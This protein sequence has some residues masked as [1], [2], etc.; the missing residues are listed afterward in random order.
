M[1][2]SRAV[3]LCISLL[4]WI[5]W[6]GACASREPM[7]TV[8][9]VDLQRFMGDWYVIA[10]I[11]AFIEKKAYDEV[12][13]YELK[14]NGRIAT[15]LTFRKGAFDGPTKTYRPSARVVEGTGNAEWRMQFLWPFESEY[16][17]IYLDDDYQ[18]TIVGRT[19]RDYAW[20]MSRSPSIP[21]AQY[22][23]LVS[24]LAD[25][26]YDTDKLREVPQS[27]R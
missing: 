18:T 2:E 20:I 9:A 15:T 10:H 4:S 24:F 8:Q 25:L 5:P 22:D 16:L 6:L 13:S 19:K 12:E 23:D 11:P 27:A 14:P 7:P 17:I 21:R 26:G 1:P 3:P